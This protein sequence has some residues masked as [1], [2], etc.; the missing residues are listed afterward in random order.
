MNFAMFI[1]IGLSA[2]AL[3]GRIVSGHGFGF[4][5]DIVVG[6]IGAFLGG[7][8]FASFLGTT[9]G[10]GVLMS[11]AVAFIGAVVLLGLLRLV[12]PTHA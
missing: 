1:L 2:G 10:G 8:L 11:M 4:V 9:G 5:G 7:W 6:I 3:A 12:A